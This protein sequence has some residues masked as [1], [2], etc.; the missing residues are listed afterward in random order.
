METGIFSRATILD[1]LESLRL[2]PRTMSD[3]E[4]IALIQGQQEADIPLAE[5]PRRFV[6]WL[7]KVDAFMQRMIDGYTLLSAQSQ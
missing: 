3:V 7:R 1:N 6:D 2:A 4:S 5:M